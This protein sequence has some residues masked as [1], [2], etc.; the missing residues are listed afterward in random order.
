V[1]NR[2]DGF[3]AAQLVSDYLEVDLAAGVESTI[4]A[5]VPIVQLGG[6]RYVASAAIYEQFEFG[7][8]DA[9]TYDLI[10][11]CFEF[12]IIPT[13]RGDTSLLYQPHEW[14]VRKESV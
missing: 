4:L 10:S 13:Y 2:E 3:V 8:S 9:V 12:E 7:N 5:S 14:V 11:R 6:G 1:L